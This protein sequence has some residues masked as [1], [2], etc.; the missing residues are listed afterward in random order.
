MASQSLIA[1]LFLIIFQLIE[2]SA[3]GFDS[4]IV[5]LGY[6]KYR[7][8]YNEGL[9][10]AEF[11]GIPFAAPPIGPLRWK[12]PQ[13]F[14]GSQDSATTLIN[15]TES[16]PACIQ[17]YPAWTIQSNVQISESEDCLKLNIFV[18][19]ATKKDEKLPVVLTIP[20]GG[21]V[22]GQADQGSP[23]AL[24]KHSNNAFIYVVIQYRLGAYGFLGS[25]SFLQEGG[26]ANIGLLDQ[27]L[28]I[29]WVQEHIEAFGG[30]PERITIQGGSAGGGSV[31][32]HLIWKGGIGKAPFRA[33]MADFPWWQ[34]FL[35]ED[36]LVRQYVHLLEAASC[37]TLSCLRKLDEQQLKQ[38]TQ[39]TYLTA[40]D[41]REYGYGNFYYGPYVDGDLI[42]DL[43]SREFSRGHFTKVPVWTSREGYEG[44]S[45]SNQSMTTQ[46]EA[47]ED[48]NMQFPYADES[49]AQSIFDLYPREHFNST[50]WQRATWFG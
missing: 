48:V 40:Y 16:G 4:P 36:Q 27:R 26:L 15:A 5:D 46:D 31:T 21:Y 20:G 42:Q 28:A 9:G 33:A 38:A 8:I 13:P 50:F 49:F 30:D 23:Y 25:K 11:R 34:Q 43:P 29:E 24:M 10:I 1:T 18:P 12:A 47:V 37:S 7:G 44:W 45:F 6:A 3:K 2:A 17:G 39:S 22:M 32:N 14:P 35:R 19:D 41:H